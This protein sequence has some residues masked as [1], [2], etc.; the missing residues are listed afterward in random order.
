MLEELRGPLVHDKKYYASNNTDRTDRNRPPPRHGGAAGRR[1]ADH[2]E[3]R[4]RLYQRQHPPRLPRRASAPGKSTFHEWKKRAEIAERSNKYTVLMERIDAALQ[5]RGE[6]DFLNR[7]PR[8]RGN[9]PDQA[10]TVS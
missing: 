1:H 9:R 4:R 3:A 8:M 5:K 7:F 2:P 10:E 6:D